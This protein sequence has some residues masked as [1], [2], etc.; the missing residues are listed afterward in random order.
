[1]E[2]RT[3]V[4][5]RKTR[6]GLRVSRLGERMAD[7]EPHKHL[8]HVT[9]FADTPMIFLTVC[10]ADRRRLLSCTDAH[11]TLHSLWQQSAERNG[12]FVGRY[13]IMPDHVHLFARQA[14]EACRMKDWIKMWKSMSTRALKLKLGLSG[15]LWQRDY[16]DRFLRSSD[17]Y[18]DKWT[19]VRNNPVRAGLVSRVEDW[20]Y[21]GEIHILKW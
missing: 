7:I 9:A 16:F 1:M 20:P 11:A 6:R 17:N 2:P 13:M 21:Q 18:S 15:S 14:R 12:W 3:P 4:R 8:A 19:Y 5:G 10:T